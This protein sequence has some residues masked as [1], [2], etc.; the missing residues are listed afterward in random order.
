MAKEGWLTVRNVP[1]LTGEPGNAY[2]QELKEFFVEH[3]LCPKCK[4]HGSRGTRE[5]DM[6][7]STTVRYGSIHELEKLKRMG[8]PMGDI[9]RDI[10]QQRVA[11][12]RNCS[13]CRGS[14]FVDKDRAK[15]YRKATK[16]KQRG[17]NKNKTNRKKKKKAC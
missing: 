5:V 7:D 9:I 14:R 1:D 8:V 17:R 2:F 15:A 4:G 13:L 11:G 12:K 6:V 16:G 3:C 10:L